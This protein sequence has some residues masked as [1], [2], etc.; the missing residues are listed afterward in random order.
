MILFYLFI[1]IFLYIIEILISTLSHIYF[2]D[3]G[4]RISLDDLNILHSIILNIKMRTV[5][6]N[7]IRK[8]QPLKIILPNSLKK[9]KK[10][11]SL[12]MLALLL[13]YDW[14]KREMSL[15]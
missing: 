9:E 3:L 5:L 13:N 10:N 1:I 4:D 8:S 15:T 2:G 11:Q 12:I 14:M 6:Y 7:T